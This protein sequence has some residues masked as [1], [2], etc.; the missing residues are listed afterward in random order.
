[1]TS[2]FRK[3]VGYMMVIGGLGIVGLVIGNTN[4]RSRNYT[5]SQQIYRSAPAQTRQENFSARQ[6][7]AEFREYRKAREAEYEELRNGEPLQ[8]NEIPI[9]PEIQASVNDPAYTQHAF[10]IDLNEDGID[11]V[12]IQEGCGSGGCWGRVFQKTN[13]GYA[14]I[15]PDYIDLLSKERT[16]GYRNAYSGDKTYLPAG[17]FTN[18]FRKYVWNGQTYV[19]SE[20][21]LDP[22]N[23]SDV[24]NNLRTFLR[25]GNASDAQKSLQELEERLG[26]DNILSAMLSSQLAPN[27][28]LPEGDE[29]DRFLLQL[30]QDRGINYTGYSPDQLRRA[31]FST[32][33]S[34]EMLRSREGLITVA[35]IS[36]ANSIAKELGRDPYSQYLNTLAKTNGYVTNYISQTGNKPNPERLSRIL[37]YGSADAIQEEEVHTHQ[38]SSEVIGT[39]R[40]NPDGT[41][42]Y[43][44]NIYPGATQQQM[45][46][47]QAQQ[48]RQAIEQRGQENRQKFENDM[49]RRGGQVIDG[50]KKAIENIFKAPPKKK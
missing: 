19:K 8:L 41:S 15:I 49:R 11:E 16:N 21:V 33:I 35:G 36:I 46:D 14:V 32:M 9:P 13:S 5:P 40:T 47:V 29:Y 22:A 31:L 6:I 1:M 2:S 23:I 34:P 44:G 25:S 26:T 30:S 20:I 12:I 37:A 27:I 42:Q 18:P 39:T 48:Q 28:P 10:A 7:P 4:I 38:G 3:A 43:I 50:T 24:S 17:G 45:R